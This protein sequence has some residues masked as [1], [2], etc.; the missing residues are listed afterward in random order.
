M[1]ERVIHDYEDELAHATYP[2]PDY[3]RRVNRLKDALAH[4]GITTDTDGHLRLQLG[5][6][7]GGPSAL[8]AP[9]ESDIRMNAGREPARS[10]A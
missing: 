1:V 2:N 9:S 8:G 5:R 7:I 10:G 3:Q 6:V 4:S